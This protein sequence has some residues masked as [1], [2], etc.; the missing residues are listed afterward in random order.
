MSAVEIEWV[1]ERTAQL[2]KVIMNAVSNVNLNGDH[3]PIKVIK[4]GGELIAESTPSSPALIAP[5]DFDGRQVCND[6]E[7]INGLTV[8][9]SFTDIEDA[10]AQGKCWRT[11][12]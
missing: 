5:G 11:P 2:N 7:W 9:H 3:L 12:V 8:D 6:A 10:M 1:R 4:P